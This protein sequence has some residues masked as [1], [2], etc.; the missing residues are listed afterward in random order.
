LSI[1]LK[2]VVKIILGWVEELTGVGWV[3]GRNPTLSRLVGNFSPIGNCLQLRCSRVYLIDKQIRLHIALP[4][5]PHLV[6]CVD[7]KQMT[8][9]K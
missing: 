1:Y 6:I 3:E 2:I 8:K 5:R 4:S 7:Q 9:D